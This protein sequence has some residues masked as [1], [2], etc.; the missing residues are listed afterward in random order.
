MSFMDPG[1]S[2]IPAVRMLYRQYDVAAL[3]RDGAN[4]LGARLG[5][6][7]YG[8]QGSFCEG[9]RGST[10]TCR[11]F[12]MNLVIRYADGSEQ[13][14][15]TQSGDGTTR[16]LGT[17][18]LNPIR[19]HERERWSL[20]RRRRGRRRVRGLLL[21]LGRARLETFGETFGASQTANVLVRHVLRAPSAACSL[22]PSACSTHCRTVECRYTK[23]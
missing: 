1:W 13:T 23:R 17:D 15:L 14:V 16:W 4:V 11:A 2:N 6:C 18:V 5:Q 8:Y 19:L 12:S 10:A 3:L 7:K 22:P 9:A 21:R 20:H